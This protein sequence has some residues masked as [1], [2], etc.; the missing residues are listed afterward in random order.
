M[1]SKS[2]T[3]FR[4]PW[5]WDGEPAILQSRATDE[6]GYVQPT[7]RQLKEVRGDAERGKNVDS[8]N[9]ALRSRLRNP[10]YHH[11]YSTPGRLHRNN[12]KVLRGRGQE[13]FEEID[14]RRGR[15]NVK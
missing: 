12:F 9:I 7:I 6:S 15:L 10:A 5:V 1:L 8:G 13:R 2:H 14:D 11:V 3:R 4:F